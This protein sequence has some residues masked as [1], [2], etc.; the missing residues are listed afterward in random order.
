LDNNAQNHNKVSSHLEY[1]PDIDGLRAIAVLAVIGFHAFPEFVRGGFVGVD[2]FFVISGYLISGIILKSLNENSFSILEFYSRRIR[3]LFPA[4]TI[5]L[6]ICLIGGW[7]LLFADEYNRLGMH[8]AAGSAFISNFTLWNE[9]GY[10]DE[11][12]NAKPLLH[13]WSL[14]IE[15]QFYLIW[16][17]ILFLLHRIRPRSI[18]LAIG[19]IAL[20][21]FILGAI[22][23]NSDPPQAFYSPASRLWELLFGSALAVK[24]ESV[25]RFFGAKSRA[26]RSATGLGCIAIAILAFDTDFLFPGWWALL[27]V[28]GTFL[29]ISAGSAHGMNSALLSTPPLVK[30]GLISFPLYLW[31]WPLLSFAHIIESGQLSAIFR[32]M[33]VAVSFLMAWVTYRHIE[34][35]VRRRPHPQTTISLVTLMVTIGTIGFHIENF[36]EFPFRKIQDAPQYFNIKTITEE[37]LASMRAGHCHLHLPEHTFAKH[38]ATI[39]DCLG[40]DNHRKNILVIG[41]SH[42]FDLRTSLSQAYKDINFLQATGSGCTPIESLHKKDIDRCRDIIR[43]IKYNFK[44]L[45]KLDGVILSAKWS[46]DFKKLA[47]DIEYFRSRG[48]PLAVFGP[49]FEFSD[50]VPKI[51]GR[52]QSHKPN[53]MLSTYLLKRQFKLD[54]EMEEF[55]KGIGVSYISKIKN[56]C[57]GGVCPA[58]SENQKLLILDYGHWTVDG[59][60]YYGEIFRTNHV[61]ERWL[62]PNEPDH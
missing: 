35:P 51:L 11:S 29:V 56:L 10:F 41:D 12:A 57:S 49:T 9:A 4:L 37:R 25:D 47:I 45:E 34:I 13:L 6:L 53:L 18:S 16:P 7:L 58:L 54:V 24:Y 50:A 33:A 30:I 8:A 2:V 40:L 39:S 42:A 23:V 3:R 22:T 1:R 44:E 52:N 19:A 20:S 38:T 36:N 15:E 31:H 48:V 21:S 55:F 32:S 14:G 27:P 17:A 26:V 28:V 61:L 5:V 60:K 62:R 46:D 59:S 43:Y